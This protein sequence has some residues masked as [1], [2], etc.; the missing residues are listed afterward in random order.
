MKN[1]NNKDRGF[2]E[3]FLITL[4]TTGPL[5]GLVWV[6]FSWDWFF[7]FITIVVLS[8]FVGANQNKL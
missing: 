5:F 7:Y 3:M 6:I 4:I 8:I 1:K 2:L